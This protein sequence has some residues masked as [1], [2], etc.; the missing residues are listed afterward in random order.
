VKFESDNRGKGLAREI[1][2]LAAPGATFLFSGELVS[3]DIGRGAL[4]VVDP[5]T[6]QRYQIFFDPTRD[7]ASKLRAGQHVR[8]S[9]DYDGTRYTA[10]DVAIE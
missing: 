9:A 10:T 6:N 5:R 1:S 8:V 4:V 7:P 3:L 2:V